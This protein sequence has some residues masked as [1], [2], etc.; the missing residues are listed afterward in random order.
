MRLFLIIRLFIVRQGYNNHNDDDDDDDDNNDNNNNALQSATVH[1]D[2]EWRM[3]DAGWRQIEDSKV[4]R[5]FLVQWSVWFAPVLNRLMRPMEGRYPMIG[6]LIVQ[7]D[8]KAERA[9]DDVGDDQ[10][11][12]K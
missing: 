1:K 6:Q 8:W 5:G 4:L 10:A 2:T 11:D 9:Q 7:L 12:D 3:Q